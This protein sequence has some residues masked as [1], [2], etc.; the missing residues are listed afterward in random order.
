MAFSF[1]EEEKA[2]NLFVRA[3]LWLEGIVKVDS[4]G[5]NS[6]PK[7]QQKGARHPLL[8]LAASEHALAHLNCT[9]T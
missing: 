3:A 1:L 7:P 8:R 2:Q 6:A 4:E 9:P 5:V